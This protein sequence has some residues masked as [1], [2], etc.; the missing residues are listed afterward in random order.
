[1]LH[2]GKHIE[3]YT[4]LRNALKYAFC[5]ICYEKNRYPVTGPYKRTQ[6]HNNKEGE[7]VCD[8]L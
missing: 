8:L 2:P 1:M 6:L 3:I 5:K 7:I 4:H